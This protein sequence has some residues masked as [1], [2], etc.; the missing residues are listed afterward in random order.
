MDVEKFCI[1]ALFNDSMN[2]LLKRSL[3]ILVCSRLKV[4]LHYSTWV[5]ETWD[6]IGLV[7]LAFIL[8][9]GVLKLG[10]CY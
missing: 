6:P 7:D 4:G 8:N 10:V 1:V 3:F 2:V 9:I 5:Q